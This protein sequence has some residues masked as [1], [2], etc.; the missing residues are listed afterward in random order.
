MG[1]LKKRSGADER[2]EERMASGE[3][4]QITFEISGHGHHQLSQAFATRLE[5]SATV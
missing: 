5:S 4:E 2:V 3:A 1:R